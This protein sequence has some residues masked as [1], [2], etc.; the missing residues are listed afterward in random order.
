MHLCTYRLLVCVWFCANVIGCF[1]FFD[2]GGN[3]R[4]P[5]SLQHKQGYFW[6][7]IICALCQKFPNLLI[8]L[9]IVMLL[10]L[11]IT[12]LCLFISAH[13]CVFYWIRFHLESMV[14]NLL[15]F[16]SCLE[17]KKL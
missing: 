13:T 14:S 4:S 2:K 9:H 15:D 3:I 8:N 6:T 16:I 17:S 7:L 10:G 12:I 5:V 11:M 1:L